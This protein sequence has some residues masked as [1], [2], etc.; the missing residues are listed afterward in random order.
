MPRSAAS[1]ASSGSPTAAVLRPIEQA[2]YWLATRPAQQTESLEGRRQADVAIVG[3]GLTGL[4]TALSLK[5]LEPRLDIAILEQGICGYGASGRNAGI[6]GETLDH[7]HELAAAHFGFAEARELAHLARQNLDELAKFLADHGIDAEFERSGQLIMA[8]TP[9]QAEGLRAAV[10]FARTLGIEDWQFLSGEEAR[11][12][13]HSPLYLGALLAPAGGTIHPVKLLDGLRREALRLGVRVFERTRVLGFDFPRGEVVVR[14]EAGSVAARKAVLAT[15]A[16]THYLLPRLSARFLPLYDYVLVSE[17]LTAAQREAIGWEKRRGVTD[18][19]TFFNYYRLTSDGRILWGTSEA[20]YFSGNR[21]D[22]A[23]DH[24]PAHYDALRES[25]RR[26][27]PQLSGLQFPY[28]WGGP[29]CSTTRLT[30]F[31]G[32]AAG[33]RLCYGLGYTGHGLGSTRLAGKILSHL[34]LD[35]DSP[36]L[37]LAMVRRKPFPYPPE[38]LRTLAVAA[39]TRA[40]RRVDAGGKPSLLLRSLQALGI[41]FSS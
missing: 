5:E 10:E 35:R 29:I 40:L 11:A 33:G 39:V 2:C 3:A 9:E 21:V 30:P 38:P 27:F 34:V 36:L 20:V 6:V 25:F 14:A 16:Y 31:F 7:S 15:N 26:H 13:I 28:A 1:D 4:W 24:S 18:A 19:R 22:A 37:Q 32:R 12:E 17:P 8:L 41:G 23:C